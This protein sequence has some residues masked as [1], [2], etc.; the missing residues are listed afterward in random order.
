MNKIILA[1]SSIYRQELLKRL[2]I[3]FSS[4]SPNIDETRINGENFEDLAR[5]LSNEKAG[6]ISVSY[7]HLRAHET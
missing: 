1:S 6:A 4:I 7:T 2:P 3:N 5:R